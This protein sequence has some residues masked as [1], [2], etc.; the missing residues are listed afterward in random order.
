MSSTALATPPDR[1]AQVFGWI[2]AGA[3]EHEIAEAIAANWPDAKAKPLIVAAMKRIAAGADADPGTVRGW[4]IEATRLIYQRAV[5]AGDLATALRA[6][7]QLHDLAG[8]EIA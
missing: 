5:E 4:C 6:I 8:K 1:I 7:R 3:A 2:V